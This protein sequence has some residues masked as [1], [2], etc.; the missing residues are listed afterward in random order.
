[1]ESTSPPVFT[2]VHIFGAIAD[3]AYDRM[4]KEMEKSV[5]PMPDGSAGSI[6]T[7]D[8]EQTAFKQA[9][10]SVVFS[11]IWLE[12]L[13]HLLIVW[14]FGKQKF[15]KVDRVTYENK[16]RLLGCKDKALLNK[17]KELRISRRELVHEKAHMEF[18]DDGNFVGEV[19]TAQDEA[20]IARAVMVG[21]RGWCKECLG[22][23]PP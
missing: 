23:D 7:V 12:A 17:V 22:L 10:I 16:L 9:M 2:N 21:V 11:S 13:L 14:R 3:T 1:M 18:D 20:E 5:H 8:P 19:T 15:K 4:A 6:R